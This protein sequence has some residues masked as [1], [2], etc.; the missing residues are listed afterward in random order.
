MENST[1]NAGCMPYHQTFRGFE[2]PLFPCLP[3]SVS[4]L[5]HTP[6]FTTH[7][8]SSQKFVKTSVTQSGMLLE[9]K[10]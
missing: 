7:R 6:V 10:G 9:I 1:S 4:L 5:I 3:V 2:T 8:S